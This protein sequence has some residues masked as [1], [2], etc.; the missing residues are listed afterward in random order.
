M[1]KKGRCKKH[2][3]ELAF[4]LRNTHELVKSCNQDHTMYLIP[5][6]TINQLSY[7]GKPVDSYRYSDHWNW[8]ANVKKCRIPDYI[9][10]YNVDISGPNERAGVGLPSAP[11]YETC[12]AYFDKDEKYHTIYPARKGIE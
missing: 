2:F 9:Q 12:I 5:K 3:M 8:Y 1:S 6:G 4:E 11:V 10:C 7:Y